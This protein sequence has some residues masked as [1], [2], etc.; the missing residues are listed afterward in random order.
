MGKVIRLSVAHRRM[1]RGNTVFADFGELASLERAQL[2]LFAACA[3]GAAL[4]PLALQL[5]AR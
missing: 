4:L 1:R 5:V 3:L 2:R